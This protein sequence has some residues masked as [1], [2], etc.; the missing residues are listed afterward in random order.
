MRRR[1]FLKTVATTGAAGSAAGQTK[2]PASPVEPPTPATSEAIRYPRV[3]TGRQLQMLGF[4]LGGIGAG[5]ISLGGRGQLRD[6]EIFNR[7]DK[8]R[9]PNYAFPSIWVKTADAKPVVRVLESRLM[10]PYEAASGLGPANAPGLQRFVSATFTGEYPLATVA[11]KDPKVPVRV[12][13]E[14]FTPIAPIDAE[15]SGLPVAILR[16]KVVNPGRRR[17]TVSIAFSIDNPVGNEAKR[18]NEFRSVGTLQG[19][20][21]TDPALAPDHSNRGSF[22]VGVLEAGDGKVT[23][24]RGW[25]RAKWWAS[26]MLFWDDFSVDGELGPEP[27]DLNTVGSICLKRDIPAGK[28]AEYTFIL[29]WHFPNRTPAGCGW[30]A[31]K[32]D[33]NAV[34]GNY[35]CTRFPDAWGAAQY[36]AANLKGLEARMRVFLAAM[37]ESTLPPAV[38]EAAMSNLSTLASNTCFRTADG[39]F[40][41]FEGTF[42]QR[43]C[44]HGTCTHVWNYESAT[45]FL[46]PTLAR[47]MRESA[48]EISAKLDGVIP[49]RLQLPEGKQTGGTTAADGT[50]GQIM[51]AYLDWQ[52]SGDSAWL[53]S[54]WPKVKRA[55]EF[56]WVEGGW[57]ADRNGVMEGVQHN[58]Y[59][60]EFYGPN[61]MCGVYYLGGLRAGEEMARAVGDTAASEE[62]RRLFDNGSQW[63]DAHLF[64]GEFY[65]QRVAGIAKE[66]IAKPLQSTGGAE[67]SLHPDFQLG[68]GCLVDQLVGQYVADY[69]GLGLLVDAAKIHK[70]LESIYKY[71]YQRSLAEHESVQRIFAL[72]DESALVICA[73]RNGK[74]PKIPFPYFAEV[75]TGFEYSAAVLMLAHGMVEQGVECIENIRRRYDGERRNAWDEAEC[76]H[77]YARAMA[78]WSGIVM[79]SG[80]RYYGPTRVVSVLPLYRAERLVSF[81]SSGAAWGQLTLTTS[82]RTKLTIAPRFGSLEVGAIEVRAAAGHVSTVTVNGKRIAHKIQ[83]I[84]DLRRV[85]VAE[86]QVLR[87]GDTLIVEV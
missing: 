18:V 85:T 71:N 28:S 15:D 29:A 6:W 49:I 12:T 32:G 38:K 53:K 84:D 44:C 35:Y 81:F 27:A 86:V 56:A 55:L 37:R 67:D 72:N 62:Y 58:T 70:T 73:Y 45:N 80:F 40:R 31:P 75:M 61:P 65:V 4:P 66:R 87:D 46:Y 36:A 16:Y 11:F 48:F 57:D 51:K 14:A 33:E 43:G 8:G 24:L 64:N 20:F 39:K 47:S 59:D 34:I 78:A 42:D 41:G 2:E 7:A 69:C 60:V 82:P 83:S 26:P 77:H 76:G 19:L 50:M 3:F 63:I 52:Q 23:T 74:R 5:S 1:T 22:V 54:I 9:S 13:L 30:S 25:P 10:P 21:M 68:E 79:L 17:A